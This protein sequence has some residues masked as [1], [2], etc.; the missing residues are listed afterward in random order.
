MELTGLEI[1]LLRLRQAT[2]HPSLVAGKATLDGI[3]IV[4]AANTASK[5]AEEEE[6]E[7]AP[8]VD[9]GLDDIV[10]GLGALDVKSNVEAV[11]VSL[12]CALC[13][14]PTYTIPAVASIDLSDSDEDE[15][16]DS[17]DEDEV[18]A[19]SKMKAAVQSA[20]C[21]KCHDDL[22]KFGNL[23]FST[24]IRQTMRIL[25]DISEEE[26]NKKTIIFSQFT[27]M[28]DLLEPFLKKAKIK[29]VRCAYGS[30]TVAR[31]VEVDSS[32]GLT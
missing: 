19:E 22:G 15:P 13:E 20:Y 25:R 32:P 9:D 18:Q 26:G 21:K 1:L 7:D 5:T 23:K 16:K 28:L 11:V 27:S 14:K 29:F 17:D 31:R 12:T 3:D 10:S 8:V 4:P 24:K 30:F 2:S 6:Q